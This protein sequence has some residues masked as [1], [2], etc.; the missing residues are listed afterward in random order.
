MPLALTAPAQPQPGSGPFDPREGLPVVPGHPLFWVCGQFLGVSLEL[1]Q[2]VKGV[3]SLELACLDETH[4]D[5]PHV[6]AILGLKEEAIVSMDYGLF[7]G[8]FDDI[9]I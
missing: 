4:K 5:I 7:Q 9:V 2:I 6:R 1:R 3:N 8:T